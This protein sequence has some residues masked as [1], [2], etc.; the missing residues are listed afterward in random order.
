MSAN[1]DVSL[2][3]NP[4]QAE[5]EPPESGANQPDVTPVRRGY[6]NLFQAVCLRS[7]KAPADST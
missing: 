2:F 7:Q 4:D 6:Q 5:T 3:E 1:D